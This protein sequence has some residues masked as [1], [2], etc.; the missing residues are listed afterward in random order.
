[1]GFGFGPG[2]G[3]GVGV[4]LGPGLSLL[5]SLP[6]SGELCVLL[7]VDEE[8]VDGDDMS[9]HAAAS[10]VIATKNETLLRIA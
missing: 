6:G 8:G 1:M 4:G 5:L 2:V 7:V 10:T 3:F 9:T